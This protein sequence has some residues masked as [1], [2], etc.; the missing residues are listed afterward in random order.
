MPAVPHAA[1]ARSGE[2]LL[3]V[4]S[5][6]AHGASFTVSGLVGDLARL[7]SVTVAYGF[8]PGAQFRIE[9]DLQ[10]LLSVEER[11]ESRIELDEDVEDG[12][13]RD[14]GD[15]RVSTAFRLL[16]DARGPA[17]GLRFE[18][19][20]PSSDERRGIGLNTTDFT[21]TVF[22]SYG[23]DG[24]RA[25]A[26]LGVAIL[27]TPLKSFD[28]ND[29]LAYAAEL[30]WEVPGSDGVR[31]ATG[32]EGRANTR[33]IVPLGLEDE[34]AWRVGVDWSTDGWIV[35]ADLSVG[36]AALSPE[37]EIRAGVARAFRL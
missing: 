17:A 12:S 6:Y 5:S 36:Y 27:E 2:L 11:R 34:G 24:V 18:M 8:A 35:D 31:L 14:F 22:G 37:W 33:G 28:Q 13:T 19:K 10:R 29:V 25:T 1:A 7:G 21:G 32:V 23:A 26:A 3:G 9:G 4:G 30:L 20:I 16:G 15:F